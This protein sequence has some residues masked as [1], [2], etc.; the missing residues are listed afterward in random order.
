[1][2]PLA[3]VAML[4]KLALFRIAR[5]RAPAL[6]NVSSASLRAVVSVL[7]EIRSVP[8]LVLVNVSPWSFGLVPLGA[9]ASFRREHILYGVVQL[10]LRVRFTKKVSAFSQQRS[11]FFG[12]GVAGR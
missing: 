2:P 11:H 9:S 4:E 1:M 5:C 6:S 7:S 3:S 8:P 12:N 10:I